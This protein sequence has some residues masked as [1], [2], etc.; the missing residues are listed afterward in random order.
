MVSVLNAYGQMLLANK[1]QLP[2][3]FNRYTEAQLHGFVESLIDAWEA[4][5]V[6]HDYA[7]TG[8]TLD[9]RRI[10]SWRS[11]PSVIG[12]NQKQVS[13]EGLGKAD[14]SRP[15]G[16]EWMESGIEWGDVNHARPVSQAPREVLEKEIR[17]LHSHLLQLR[18]VYAA[19]LL[20][21]DRVLAGENVS[22]EGLCRC[23]EATSEEL[24]D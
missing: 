12:K 15:P 14:L 1:G 19:H 9:H 21:I 2:L 23:L 6:L 3:D 20:L 16:I 11:R 17:M 18:S 24:A 7:P 8:L 13:V 5:S 22:E 10:E 4:L